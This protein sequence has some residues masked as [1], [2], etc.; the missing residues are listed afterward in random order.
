[1][2]GEAEEISLKPRTPFLLDSRPRPTSRR[3]SVSNAII[4]KYGAPET[5]QW[6]VALV[7]ATAGIWPAGVGTLVRPPLEEIFFHHVE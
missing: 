3:A 1:M 5:P 2:E 4:C 7:A 6:R